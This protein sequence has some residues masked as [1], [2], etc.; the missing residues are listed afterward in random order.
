MK[1][2]TMP[3]FHLDTE[4]HL[5]DPAGHLIVDAEG[6]TVGAADLKPMNPLLAVLLLYGTMFLMIAAQMGLVLW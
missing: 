3:S 1:A 4:G 2:Y 6:H 5:V